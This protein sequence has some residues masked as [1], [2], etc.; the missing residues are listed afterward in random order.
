MREL[1]LEVKTD[2][3][4]ETIISKERAIIKKITLKDNILLKKD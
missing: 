1:D 4:V 2:L 3:I